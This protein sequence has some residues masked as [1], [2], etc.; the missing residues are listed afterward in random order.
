LPTIPENSKSAKRLSDKIQI[1]GDANP[2]SSPSTAK[3]NGSRTH[4]ASLKITTPT[5][6]RD[7]SSDEVA[8]AG[9]KSARLP[10]P[11]RDRDGILKKTESTESS[12]STKRNRAVVGFE[13]AGEEDTEERSGTKSTHFDKL[14]SFFKKKKFV[15]SLHVCVLL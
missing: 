15:D 13:H 5:A 2:A 1:T 10:G 8:N 11:R 14:P 9:S 6:S 12:S 7:E 4:R 3:R